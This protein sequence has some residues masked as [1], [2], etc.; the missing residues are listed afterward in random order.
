MF[1]Y[2]VIN[3]PDEHGR[4]QGD[5]VEPRLTEDKREGSAILLFVTGNSPDEVEEKAKAAAGPEAVW[6]GRKWVI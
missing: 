1:C 2:C 4:W 5:V 6:L 3:G